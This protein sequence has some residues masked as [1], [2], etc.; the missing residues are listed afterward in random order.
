MCQIFD[1]YIVYHKGSRVRKSSVRDTDIHLTKV[2]VPLN[3]FKHFRYLIFLGDIALK[4]K[5][6]N[7]FAL[8]GRTVQQ[9][10]AHLTL[11]IK[12]KFFQVF[13]RSRV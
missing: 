4:T 7:F 1:Y 8:Q 2:F 11:T 12:A 9:L 13:S 3:P 5:S 10:K 6:S